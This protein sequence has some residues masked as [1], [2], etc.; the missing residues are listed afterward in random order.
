MRRCWPLGSDSPTPIQCFVP[1]TPLSAAVAAALGIAAL[2]PGQRASRGNL[3]LIGLPFLPQPEYDRLLWACDLNFVR[4][5]D[6]FVRAQWAA[7][8]LIWNIYPQLDSVHQEKLEA[9]L[10]LYCRAA[11]ET[12]SLTELWRAWNGLCADPAVAWPGFAATLPALN[13]H[14]RRWAEGLE[15]QSD[16]A[17]QLVK[18][19][20]KPL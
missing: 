8:P 18:F 1:E 9:F 3:T 6:S 13:R 19:S 20:K 12:A 15:R 4:G 17:T 2:T 5:E 11:P 14:A 7:R 10:A 16:L